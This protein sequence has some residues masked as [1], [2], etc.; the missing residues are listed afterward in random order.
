MQE[1]SRVHA[2]SQIVCRSKKSMITSA[3]CRSCACGVEVFRCLLASQWTRLRAMALPHVYD[4]GAVVF[5]EGTPALAVYCIRSGSLRLFRR[6]N[7]GDE[8]VVGMREPG[9]LVGLRAVVSRL[10]YWSTAMTIERATVCAIPAERFLELAGENASLALL[11]LKR[12]ALESRLVEDQLV[13]R[14]HHRV[15]KRTA[16]FLVQ[17][18]QGHARFVSPRPGREITMNREEMARL[19]GTTPETLSRTLHGF[20]ER[21]ILDLDRKLIRI[22]D[23]DAL[24]RLAD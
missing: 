22:R 3:D 21:G 6:M 7:L 19:I 20:G 14:N 12:M 10:P 1:A 5:H 2:R 17:L 24:V 9:D 15:G 8:V 18:A 4:A 11:L 13:G 23:L 16:R